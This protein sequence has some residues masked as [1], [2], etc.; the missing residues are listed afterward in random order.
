MTRVLYFDCSYGVAGDMTLGALVD[1]GAPFPAI[2]KALESGLGV[3]GIRLSRSRVTRSGVSAVR[4][5][6]RIDAHHDH[7]RHLRH[8]LEIIDQ[9]DLP[10]RAK[11]RARKAYG[12]LAESEAK[13]HRSTPEKIH[14][15]EVGA[16]DAIADVAGSMLALELLGVDHIEASPIALGS[17]TA[18]CAHGTIPVPAPATLE[19]LKGVPT[20]GSGFRME[21]T[22]PTGAAILRAVA[23]GFGPQPPM[24]PDRSGYGSGFARDRGACEFPA[25]GGGRRACAGGRVA[26]A[27]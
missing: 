3:K 10:D 12:F 19:L 24:T 9:A 2:K 8:V 26:R 14:F 22:T 21:M 6:V 20:F 13:V 23:D 17:G 4:V 15:H 16:L 5:H 11:E 18:R 25:R 7:H 27:R 1:A